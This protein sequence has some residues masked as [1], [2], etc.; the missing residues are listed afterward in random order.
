MGYNPTVGYPGKLN[1]PEAGE[2]WVT[3]FLNAGQQGGA[4]R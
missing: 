4:G 2:W 3:D 1:S